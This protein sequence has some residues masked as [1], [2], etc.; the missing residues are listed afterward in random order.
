MHHDK[1]SFGSREDKM[2]KLTDPR[3]CNSNEGC[4]CL[5]YS[6]GKPYCILDYFN[7]HNTKEVWYNTETGEDAPERPSN[8]DEWHLTVS[9]PEK[10]IEDHGEAPFSLAAAEKEEVIEALHNMWVIHLKSHPED[11]WVDIDMVFYKDDPSGTWP[12]VLIPICDVEDNDVTRAHNIGK[13]F[14]PEV[15]DDEDP[16][17]FARKGV[18]EFL[19]AHC[20]EFIVGTIDRWNFDLDEQEGLPL[21]MIAFRAES[22]I[23]KAFAFFINKFDGSLRMKHKDGWC[24]FTSG[25]TVAQ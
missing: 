1:S 4:P 21:S 18:L 11:Y 6:S 24:F 23:G 22:S 20:L 17:V 13:C 19:Q 25:G 5:V 14:T 3:F 12:V 9:R 10:C 7:A 16:P 8:G 15:D 2:I